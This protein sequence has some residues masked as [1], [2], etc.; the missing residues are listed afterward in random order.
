MQFRKILWAPLAASSL[1]GLGALAHAALSDATSSH[2]SFQASGPAGLKIEGTTSDLTLA[3]QGD[4]V[5]ITVPL[6]NLATG[7]SV[8]DKHMKEKYLEVPKFPSATLTVKRSALKVP[9]AGESVA[10]D[11][12][13]AVN[14]HGQTRPVTVHYEV[15]RDGPTLTTRGRFHI[16]MGD[17]GITVPSYLG[18]TV[19]PDVDVSADFRA[20]GS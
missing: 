9:S 20:A 1:L 15:K 4:D 5:V 14:L 10:L 13:G 12:A 17:F 11:V 18:V 16:N 3:D 7:I 8:R 19:K 2:V 6:A